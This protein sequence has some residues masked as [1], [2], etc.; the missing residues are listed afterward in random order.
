MYF[1]RSFDPITSD[2]HC[3]AVKE[4]AV[5][6]DSACSVTSNRIQKDGTNIVIDTSTPFSMSQFCIRA[7]TNGG[8]Y[9]S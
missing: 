4:Y 7:E 5:F 2:L 1:T 6:S 9:E 8:N 3:T